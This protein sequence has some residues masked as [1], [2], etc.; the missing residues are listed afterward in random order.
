MTTLKKSQF[1]FSPFNNVPYNE[2]NV[3]GPWSNGLI[4]RFAFYL[5]FMIFLGQSYVFFRNVI[6]VFS[7]LN[8]LFQNR[9][10]AVCDMVGDQAELE[11]NW[12][13]LKRG[14]SSFLLS[15]MYHIMNATFGAVKQWADSNVCSLLII[16]DFLRLMKFM[17]QFY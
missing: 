12:P 15:T 9:R 14:N 3:W 7:I 8:M 16:R 5:L 17:D 4:V 10:A 13:H 2:C 11:I 6:K 1:F